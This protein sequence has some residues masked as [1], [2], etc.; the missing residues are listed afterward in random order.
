MALVA[1]AVLPS[2][3]ALRPRRG[4][5][6]RAGV[7]PLAALCHRARAVPRRDRRRPVESAHRPRTPVSRLPG[8]RRGRAR[9]PR[10]TRRPDRERRLVIARGDICWV[11]LGPII[12]HGPT[13][14]RPVLVVQSDAYTRSRLQTVIVAVLSSSTALA[15]VPGAVF[16]PAAVTGLPKDSVVLQPLSAPRPRARRADCSRTPRHRRQGADARP[17]RGRGSSR[18]LGSTRGC[19]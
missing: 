2:R 4:V 16:A 1:V 9:R 3:P 15:A 11:D 7:E 8:R 12:D 10:P 5:C 17:P 19:R 14:R 13:K 6:G 18:R